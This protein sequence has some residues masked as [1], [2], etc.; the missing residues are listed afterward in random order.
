MLVV[1]IDELEDENKALEEG[2]D[3][4]INVDILKKEA[5]D[6]EDR[7]EAFI[8]EIE[9]MD[10]ERIKLQTI[11][12]ELQE[13][14]LDKVDDSFEVLELK[15]GLLGL[16]RKQLNIPR[17][18]WKRTVNWKPHWKPWSEK[19]Q[20]LSGVKAVESID[21][22]KEGEVKLMVESKDDKSNKEKIAKK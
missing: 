10:A 1:K 9:G 17:N 16:R 18:L 13:K 4:V 2:N 3:E 12:E 7:K 14:G 20:L 8:K 22:R 19:S 6:L 11:V 5:K 21:G 15:I